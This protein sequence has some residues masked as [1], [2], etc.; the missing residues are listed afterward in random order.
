M[1]VIDVYILY[2]D[3]V[4]KTMLNYQC[5]ILSAEYMKREWNAAFIL[6]L[7]TKQKHKCIGVLWSNCGTWVYNFL[8]QTENL[9][10]N[11]V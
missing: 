9:I 7:C 8:I 5:I 4:T 2:I 3:T 10:F 11:N 1:D 6:Y